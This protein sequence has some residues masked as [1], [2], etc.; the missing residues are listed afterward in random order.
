[1]DFPKR[2]DQKQDCLLDNFGLSG[3]YAEISRELSTNEDD[4]NQQ[5]LDKVKSVLKPIYVFLVLIGWRPIIVAPYKRKK[6]LLAKVWN[7]VWPIVVFILLASTV[8]LQISSCDKRNNFESGD[9]DELT[10]CLRNLISFYIFPAGIILVSYSYMLYLIRREQS[11]H[12][13]NMME[14]VFLLYHQ[15]RGRY[16]KTTLKNTVLAFFCIS[17]S[18]LAFS[19]ILLI[20][21]S[22]LNIVNKTPDLITIL[23]N[24][25]SSHSAQQIIILIVEPI[26]IALYD[27]FYISQL[28]SYSLQAQLLVYY[29][30]GL[31]DRI[32]FKEV[33]LQDAIQEIGHATE[34]LR[35]LNGKV[36]F[37]VS[38]VMI[39]IAL[40]LISTVHQ[41]WH[42]VHSPP[43][44][45]VGVV[46]YGVLTIIRW[47]LILYVPL[48]QAMLIT[49]NT[50]RITHV[51]LFLKTR[52][53]GYADT[54]QE[55]LNYFQ[56]YT[57]HLNLRGK[58]F[59]IP[60]HPWVVTI[61]VLVQLSALVLWLNFDPN[62]RTLYW[63]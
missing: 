14:R 55:D 3:D 57:S 42:S 44:L 49:I 43:P 10:D 53:F 31:T 20:L 26:P 5:A 41:L 48:I 8:L 6:Y 13:A 23:R 22:I 32:K 33:K 38:L 18:W 9:K 28:L 59:S 7:L 40:E 21:R 61:I 4:E 19:I 45:D 52:P 56:L 1:M 24:E 47:L 58:L 17:V 11:E 12:F 16:S 39:N 25:S 2:N 51:G 34:I 35:T 36:A 29:F 27:L 46:I 63:L 60:I 54:S 30:N 50:K 15:K 37:S 62:I